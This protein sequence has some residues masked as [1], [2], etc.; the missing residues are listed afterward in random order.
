MC[1]YPYICKQHYDGIIT[2]IADQINMQKETS[3]RKYVTN[4][5]IHY[6]SNTISQKTPEVIPVRNC[7]KFIKHILSV[8][9][10]WPAHYG[11]AEKRCLSFQGDLAERHKWY[12]YA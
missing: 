9:I 8:G 11:V 10:F 4:I 1:H 12:L 2:W 6:L 7:S 5:N 3:L